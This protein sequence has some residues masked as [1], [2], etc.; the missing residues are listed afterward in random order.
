MIF[1]S[2]PVSPYGRIVRILRQE[3]KL[4]EKVR[5]T[6]LKIRGEDNSYYDLN[7][8]GRVPA[9]VLDDGRILKESGL[10]LLVS[11]SSRRYTDAS[12]AGRVGGIGSSQ[13]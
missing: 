9:L 8:S 4:E 3:K 12:S 11:R 6:V 5:L 10:L 1:Y 2:S 13:D 7:P